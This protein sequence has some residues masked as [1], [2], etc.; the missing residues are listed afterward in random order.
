M[1]YSKNDLLRT[2]IKVEKVAEIIENFTIY[3]DETK[4]GAN[5]IIMWDDTK[6]TLPIGL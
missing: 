2:E 6:A 3:F 4:N 1:N 5:L